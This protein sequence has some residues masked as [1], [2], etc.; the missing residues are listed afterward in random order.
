MKYLN[1]E[2]NV[3]TISQYEIQEVAGSLSAVKHGRRIDLTPFYCL[4]LIIVHLSN[5]N[6]FEIAE[7]CATYEDYVVV[8]DKHGVR[9]KAR[10]VHENGSVF[11]KA[12][13]NDQQPS[14]SEPT[15]STELRNINGNGR[16]N[17]A[18]LIYVL[19]LLGHFKSGDVLFRYSDRIKHIYDMM[20]HEAGIDYIVGQVLA[21]N[22]YMPICNLG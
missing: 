21:K 12:G 6:G 14:V 1:A 16:N 9:Y 20:G 15:P 8:K 5:G 17:Q 22:N 7:H 3:G 13:N 19:A 10:L 4:G 2:G 18:E 11:L